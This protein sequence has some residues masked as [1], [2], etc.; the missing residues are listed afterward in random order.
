MFFECGE[1]G[2]SVACLGEM[3]TGLSGLACE[4][5]LVLHYRRTGPV[6]LG[7]IDGVQFRRFLDLTPKARPRPEIAVRS[8]GI[9]RPTKFGLRYFFCALHAL[10]HF[11]PDVAYLNNEIEADIPAAIA[12]K[13]LGIPTVCHL[14]IARDLHPIERVFAKIVDQ[15]VVLTRAGQQIA[16]ANGIPERK[17]T[18][19][20]DPFDV[21]A[22]VKRT[23]ETPSLNMP[24]NNDC[25][26]VIQVGSLSARKRPMLAIDAFAIARAQCPK[27]HLIL[28]GSGPLHGVVQQEI[29][30]RGLDGSVHLIGNCLYIPAL[31][32]RCDMGLFV[33]A[34]EGLGLVILEY[35]AAG[36]PV[37]TWNMPVFR[38]LVK[39]GHTGFLVPEPTPE[40][41]AE[42]MIRL[43]RSAEL[44][45]RIGNAGREWV[46]QGQFDISGYIRQLYSLLLTVVDGKG[47]RQFSEVTA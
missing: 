20:Y 6:D 22:F 1:F 30:I 32:A 23:T 41:F 3:I 16:V 31:L 40:F 15:F 26:Y 34:R 27:L 24:W 46:A 8:F 45:E 5:G 7:S 14:R 12:A 11:R 9:P 17:L 44:R 35:M 47:G 36:L 43:Y 21:S 2:G 25:V 28:A 33:S 19:I 10:R 4:V 42:A 38:E 37:V 39:D 18:Q 29:S 13:L